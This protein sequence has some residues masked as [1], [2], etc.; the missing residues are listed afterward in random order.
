MSWAV[1][2]LARAVGW[3]ADRPL[4]MLIVALVLLFLW[5][6]F[7]VDQAR[8]LAEDRR[9]QA[10]AWQAKF[11][12]Q[13]AEMRKFEGLVRDARIEAAR[14]DRENDARVRAEWTAQLSEVKHGY[15]VD[16]ASARARLS[17]RMRGDA[18]TGGTRLA[19]DVG[20]ADLSSLPI[21]SSGPLR[22]GDAAIVDGADADACTVNTVRLEHLVD[23]WTRAASINVNGR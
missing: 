5:L 21:L 14:L 13:R 1:T 19:G 18:S 11:V 16:L 15:Q 9:V 22:P 6:S 12:E 8:D 10:A 17:Q 20:G 7:A 4:R 23:A 2:L 3:V